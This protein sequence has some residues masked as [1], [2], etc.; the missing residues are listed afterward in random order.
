MKTFP[1]E[2]CRDNVMVDVD[3]EVL[4]WKEQFEAEHK[5]LVAMDERVEEKQGE[6]GDSWKTMPITVLS[7]RLAQNYI[8]WREAMLHDREAEKRKLVDLANLCRFLW[9]RL[10]EKEILGGNRETST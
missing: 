5:F 4:E 3:W 6:H 8:E 1:K 2:V 7:N 9:E 10:N